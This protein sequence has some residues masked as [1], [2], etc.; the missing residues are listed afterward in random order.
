ME[1]A[2]QHTNGASVAVDAKWSETRREAV[3]TLQRSRKALGHM[4]QEDQDEARGLHQKIEAAVASHDGRTLN[5]A[6]K[7]L[8]ELL[9]F[10]EGN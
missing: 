1:A 7:T 10:V 5:E 2:H 9:F 8:K 3:E 6:V 4:H